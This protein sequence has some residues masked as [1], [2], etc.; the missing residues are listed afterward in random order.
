MHACCDQRERSTEGEEKR[1]EETSFVL[2]G[3]MLVEKL[4]GGGVS[5]MFVFLHIDTMILMEAAAFCI[6]ITHTPMHHADAAIAGQQAGLPGTLGLGG[7]WA[8]KGAIEKCSCSCI[9]LHALPSSKVDPSP[10][11]A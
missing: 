5:G 1:E 6:T 7:G 10:P 11:P 3:S 4:E 9:A 2:F 8:G